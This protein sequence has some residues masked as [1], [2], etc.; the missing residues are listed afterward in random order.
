[1]DSWGGLWEVPDG[2]QE[3]DHLCGSYLMKLAVQ[4][5]DDRCALLW[6]VTETLTAEPTNGARAPLLSAG[7]CPGS[8]CALHNL[9]V[10][11]L[12]S[13]LPLELS[14]SINAWLLCH[15]W[16]LTCFCLFWETALAPEAQVCLQ[17]WLVLH[18]LFLGLF[19]PLCCLLLPRQGSCSCMTWLLGVW[20]RHLTLTTG[21][22]GP[23]P[24]HQTRYLSH[25]SKHHMLHVC[26]CSSFLQCCVCATGGSVGPF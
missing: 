10:F 21:P 13:P 5:T 8:S 25:S 22:C 17:I 19:C 20:W 23:L 15:C 2:D 24:F 14:F 16:S 6:G 9:G 7:P 1:M 26:L 3:F 18:E 4:E 11:P 12:S